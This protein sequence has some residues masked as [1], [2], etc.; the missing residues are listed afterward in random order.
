M[1]QKENP[2]AKHFI[3]AELLFPLGQKDT[4]NFSRNRRKRHYKAKAEK[5]P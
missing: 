4:A 5:A 3:F 2:K 1:R